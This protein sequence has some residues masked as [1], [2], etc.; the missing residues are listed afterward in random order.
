MDKEV[1]QVPPSVLHVSTQHTWGPE[2]KLTFRS[3]R[4]QRAQMQEILTGKEAAA[5]SVTAHWG[6]LGNGRPQCAGMLHVSHS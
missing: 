6:S 3:K 1:S 2:I 5:D 4:G